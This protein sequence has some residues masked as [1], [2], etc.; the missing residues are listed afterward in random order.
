MWQGFNYSF[1]DLLFND[2]FVLGKR[3]VAGANIVQ[4]IIN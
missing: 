2:K 3:K 1:L 4:S